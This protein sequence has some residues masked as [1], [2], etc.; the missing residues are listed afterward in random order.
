M[1]FYIIFVIV[2]QRISIVIHIIQMIS[3]VVIIEKETIIHVIEFTHLIIKI[4]GTIMFII[5]P[6]S[7]S[8]LTLPFSSIN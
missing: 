2:I 7:L 4:V 3:N 8:S 5:L 1:G 6:T